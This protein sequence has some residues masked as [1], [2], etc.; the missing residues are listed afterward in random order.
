[1]RGILRKLDKRE[2]LTDKEYEELLKYIDTLLSSSAESYD[3]F[4]TRY[5]SVLW[6]DYS[7]Y[8]PHFKYDIDDLINHLIYH[9]ELFDTMAGTPDMLELFPVEMHPYIAYTLKQENH[10][11]LKQ[12]SRS[13]A[14]PASNPQQLP[15][16]RSGSVVIKYEDAN[17][18]KEIGLKSHFK[19]LSK[20][21]FITRLQSYRYLKGSK[22]SQDRIDVLEA[23]KL[24]GIYT[25]KE[26][27][28]YYYIFLNEK[29]IIKA[30]NACYVLNIALY[31]RS[32]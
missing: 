12:L 13:L 24:G 29:D 5:S 20:Y 26:K 30:E 23:D 16:A 32:N 4:Y 14:E 6:R 1:M 7:V 9:P 3:L 11:L 31:G 17:P 18:Y 22:A 28:I 10:Y 15:S 2:R 27:S 8:I 21:Q 19:R 25:N